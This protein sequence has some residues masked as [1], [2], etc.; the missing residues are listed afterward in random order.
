MEFVDPNPS[1][2][3]RPEDIGGY[4]DGELSANRELELD[5]HFANCARCL[6]ELNRQ[7]DIMR[8]L[9]ENFDLSGAPDL[10]ENF[11]KRVSVAAVSDIGGI[12]T[13]R[14]RWIAIALCG[15]LATFAIAALGGSTNEPVGAVTVAA[16][17]SFTI[18]TVVGHFFYNLAI[19]FVTLLRPISHSVNSGALM[20]AIAGI[21]GFTLIL[22]GLRAKGSNEN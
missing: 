10:P 12:R 4:L 18:L 2:V 11:A 14:E 22:F 3:C 19:G 9:D 20:F 8:A 15:L 13:K 7:K 1:A 16:E 17:R 5:L 21:L 6:D